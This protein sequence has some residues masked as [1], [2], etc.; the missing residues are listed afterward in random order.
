MSLYFSW[1]KGTMLIS[2]PLRSISFISLFKFSS[3]DLS[4]TII[5][6]NLMF[7]YL[8]LEKLTDLINE[9]NALKEYS[10]FG[11]SNNLFLF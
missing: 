11:S 3:L 9:F 7:V 1:F 5:I 10:I 8:V 2:K 4:S 6:L